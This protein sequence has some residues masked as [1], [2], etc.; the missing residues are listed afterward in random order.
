MNAARVIAAQTFPRRTVHLDFH[1]GPDVPD[2]GG[3]F[4]PDQFAST[5]AAAHVDS[6]TLFAKCHHGQLYFATDRP[7]RHPSL[8]ADLDLLGAQIE[9]LHARGIRA[10]IYLSVQVDEAS[11]NA[12]PEWVALTE[13]LRQVKW[14]GSAFEAGWQILD[15]SSPYQDHVAGQLDEVLRRFGPV[16]GIFLDMCWDQ[17]SASRWA[18]D[19]A[20]RLGLDPRDPDDRAR[21]A[22]QLAHTYM[23]RFR[24][25]IEPALH[26]DSAMGVWFNSRPKTNLHEEKKFLRHVEI[27]SLPT[28]GWGYAY[29]P[30]VGR[31]V[32]PLGLPTLSHT[33]RFHRSWGDNSGLKP[34]AALKYECCQILS[35]GLTGGVGDL[36]HPRGRVDE[37]TYRMI[38]SVYAHVEACEP[39]VHGGQTVAEVAVVVDPE[40]GDRPGP[41]GIGT[42]RALQ[43]LRQQFDIVP[44]DTDL[45]AYEV[46]V[47]PETT[48]VDEALRSSL[49]AFVAGGGGLLVSGP[50]AVDDVG[51]PVLDELG[52]EV[53]GESP[54][55]HTFLRPFE[56]LRGVTADYDTVCYERGWRITPKPGAEALCG[57]VEP[58]F[59]RSYDRFSGHSYTAPDALS[60]Y[61]AIVQNGRVITMGEPLLL[62]FGRHANVPYRELVGGCLDRLLPRPRCGRVGRST[63]R[64]R[65]CAPPT[66]WSSTCSVSCPPGRP[67]DSIWC[68]T[69]SRSSTY[70]CPSGSTARLPGRPSNR[71]ARRWRSRPSTAT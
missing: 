71:R 50:A 66:P 26:P 67:T 4:D 31:F 9:A 33:G 13:E 22:R 2:V 16:D 42:V 29:L 20:R 69:R 55:T 49:Q 45:G 62:A 44:P 63:S 24:D 32:Q 37:E 3:D 48:R 51:R 59:E 52:V 53:H 58:Y 39:F 46:V 27:E 14:G 6:V 7:E 35:R 64:R 5:F 15:M 47:L 18:V 54:Y 11:A 68:T 40:L 23:G 1:T 34:D 19:G 70:R 8:P 12:H 43:Q 21:Y 61:A 65:W 41:A 25:M 36:L 10:P 17:P 38:G 56:A 28:G 57:V 30:Y 60:D